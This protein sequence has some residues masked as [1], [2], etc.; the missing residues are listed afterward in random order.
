MNSANRIYKL[1]FPFK[2][3]LHSSRKILVFYYRIQEL[4]KPTKL[5]LFINVHFMITWSR[6]GY[7]LVRIY[8]I[9]LRD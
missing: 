3:F 8:F 1:R 5:N 4:V 6:F 9:G 2:T 7:L